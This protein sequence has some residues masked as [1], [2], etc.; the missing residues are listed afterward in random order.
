MS[1]RS[2]EF[3]MAS[4]AS[5]KYFPTRNSARIVPRRSIAIDPGHVEWPSA[6]AFA[7]GRAEAKARLDF[8]HPQPIHQAGRPQDAD[9]DSVQSRRSA[10]RQDRVPIPHARPAPAPL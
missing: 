10:G 8:V 7:K 3:V 4:L 9:R 6:L 5:E 2:S 1:A